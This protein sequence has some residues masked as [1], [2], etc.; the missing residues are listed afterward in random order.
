MFQGNYVAEVAVNTCTILGTV[1][2]GVNPIGVVFDGTY[3]WVSNY[4]SNS[5]TKI[6]A[7]TRAVVATYAVGSQPRGVTYD[8]LAVYVANYGSNSVTRLDKNSGASSTIP[9]GSGPYFLMYNPADGLIYV[10]NRNSNTVTILSGSTVLRSVATDGQPQFVSPDGNRHV[11]IS[12]SGTNEI[13]EIAS[14]GT[15]VISR[16]NAPDET[17]L[18]LTYSPTSGLLWIGTNSGY[19]FS[20]NPANG[21]VSNITFRGGNSHPEYDVVFSGVSSHFWNTDTDGFVNYLLE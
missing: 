16:V 13:D 7:S 8:G 1:G 2:T 17:P 4:G 3:V 6:N 10:P 5:V 19:L 20:I 11:W 21:A 9:V 12:C 15:T 18:G 14:N